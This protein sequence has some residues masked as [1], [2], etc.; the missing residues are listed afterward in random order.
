MQSMLSWLRRLK[1]ME[2]RKKI[3]LLPGNTILFACKFSNLKVTMISRNAC[4]RELGIQLYETE[5]QVFPTHRVFQNSKL[6]F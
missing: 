6:S 3:L 2:Q 1:V 4:I 5:M